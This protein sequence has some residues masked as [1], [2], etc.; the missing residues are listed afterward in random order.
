[1]IEVF[2]SALI[3]IF[4]TLSCFFFFE[5]YYNRKRKFSICCICFAIT[6]CILF[7]ISF[8]STPIINL[9][10]FILCYFVVSLLC[11]ESKLKSSIFTS[12]IL[13]VI[14]L[15]TEMIVVHGLSA[16]HK[17]D[18]TLYQDDF[19]TFVVQSSLSKLFYFVFLFVFTKI[20]N[21][22]SNKI[23]ANKFTLLLGILPLVSVILLHSLSH[24][25]ITTSFISPYNKVL[26]ISSIL[27][28]FA[29]IF[30]FYVYEMVQRTNIENT[31][32]K[33][34]K[35]RNEVSRE[36]YEE[37]YQ[38]LENS[39]ILAHDVKNHFSSIYDISEENNYTK[40]K[41]YVSSIYDNFGVNKKITYSGNKMVDVIINR[42]VNKCESVGVFLEVEGCRSDLK[43]MSD[44]DIV[45]LLTNMFDNA[46]EA[47]KQ[48]RERDILFSI[49]VR[50][51]NFIIIQMVNSCDV[52]P[53]S[54]NGKLISRK[55][56]PVLHGVGTRSIRRVAEKYNGSFDW[57]YNELT[58]QFEASVILNIN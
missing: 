31:Q 44:V 21:L 57:Q 5:N 15:I 50:N 47:A 13:A 2:C 19:L 56:D 32:L 11:Y 29:N 30:V 40:V 17:V 18:Y 48:S 24:L 46:I 6:F 25:G 36:L 33:L 54:Q 45:S 3:Y 20:F 53:K 22:K 37:M 38:A 23:K 49:Y 58:R 41:E 39:R 27:L 14:M 28:L 9:S 26:A 43:F 4:E 51:S 55:K 12:L 35:Q 52:P 16:I 10:A 8:L 1:M 42:Y 7:G 34:E